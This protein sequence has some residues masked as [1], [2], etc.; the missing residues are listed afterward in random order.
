MVR[1]L[2]PALMLAC[3][4]TSASAAPAT[5]AAN[6]VA[7]RRLRHQLNAEPDCPV[8]TARLARHYLANDRPKRAARLYRGMLAME[9]VALETQDGRVVSSHALAGAALRQAA[10]ERSRKLATR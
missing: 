9:D 4:A 1:M 10:A 3:A 5:D 7:E 6:E 2:V 8:A